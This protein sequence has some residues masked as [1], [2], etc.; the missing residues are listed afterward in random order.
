MNKRIQYFDIAKGILILMVVIGHIAETGPA[1]QFVYTFHMPAFFIISGIMLRYSSALKKPLYKVIYKKLYTLVIPLL[2]FELIGVIANI[3]S[4]GFSLNPVGYIYQTLILNFNNGPVWFIWAL[5]RAEI[6]FIILHRII[7]NKYCFI[8]AVSVL[9]ML[10]I[11]FHYLRMAGSTGIG[12]L[13][14]TS[15]YYMAGL[16]TKE[17]KIEIVVISIIITIIC[18]VLNGKVDLGTWSFGLIPL[19]ITGSIAGTVFVIEISKY[20]S[21]KLLI[22]YGQNSLTIMGTHQAINLTYRVRMGIKQYTAFQ[23]LIVFIVI[24][25]MEIPI[26]WIFN[27]Y[28]PFLIGKTS[29]FDKVIHLVYEKSS[30]G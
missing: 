3:L 25:A 20:L 2:F 26:I 30:A 18:C 5:F 19:Y 22:Y 6:L 15:G 13:F 8:I 23:S 29:F 9:G 12:F 17:K 14:L 1:N 16:F 11:E 27:R 28:I 10:M 4:F 7:K 24:S 21:S